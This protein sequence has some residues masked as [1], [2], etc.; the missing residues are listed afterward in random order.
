MDRERYPREEIA[1]ASRMLAM[2]VSS[3]RTFK[4]FF[5]GTPKPTRVTRYPAFLQVIGFDQADTGRV[6]LASDNRV[7]VTGNYGCKDSGF[8]VVTRPEW[9][10]RSASQLQ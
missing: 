4:A 10:W 3:S 1:R 2:T 8:V 9:L 5:G 7:V 6:I